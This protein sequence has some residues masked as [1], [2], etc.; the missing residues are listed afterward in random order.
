MA[1]NRRPASNDP[2][3]SAVANGP[4]TRSNNACTGSD[5]NRSRAWK[6]ADFD[7]SLTGSAPG[8]AHANPSVINPNTSS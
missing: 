1:T 8:S 2:G 6:I 5:P 7:G 3:V 4:A